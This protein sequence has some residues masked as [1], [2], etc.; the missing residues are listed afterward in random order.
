MDDKEPKS[1][2]D[3]M[4]DGAKLASSRPELPKNVQRVVVVEIVI[5]PHRQ[6]VKERIRTLERVKLGA[7]DDGDDDDD[8]D[9][10]DENR[11][12][13][14]EIEVAKRNPRTHWRRSE[15]LEHELNEQLT[16]SNAKCEELTIQ[17][18]SMTLSHAN[19]SNERDSMS[20]ALEDAKFALE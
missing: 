11:R 14:H 12:N 10:D 4:R 1:L 18:K 2:A 5:I 15:L 16:E 7:D 17:L 3:A 9:D 19:A 6:L 13:S 8:D 20:R